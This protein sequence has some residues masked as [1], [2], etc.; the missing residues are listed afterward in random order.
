[1]GQIQEIILL[2]ACLILGVCFLAAAAPSQPLSARPTPP[3]QSNVLRAIWTKKQSEAIQASNAS[4]PALL[5]YLGSNASR[6]PRDD[7]KLL[8][9]YTLERESHS[10]F[11]NTTNH[12]CTAYYVVPTYIP[13]SRHPLTTSL[14][15]MTAPPLR[16]HAM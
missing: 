15:F 11:V 14:T 9:N 2:L 7:D 12:S 3:V 1:M 6:C 16:P 13:A 8:I 4:T 10:Y 5:R